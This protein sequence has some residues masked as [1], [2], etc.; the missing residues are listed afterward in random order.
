M[1][2][3]PL[4]I[5]DLAA[6]LRTLIAQVPPGKATTCGG[7]AEALGNGVA[8]RWIGHFLLHH[9][10]GAACFCHRV[11]RAGGRL[12]PYI[13]GGPAEKRRRL[14]AEGVAAGDEAVDLDRCGFDRFVSDRPLERLRRLQE[15]TAAEV[16]LR[17]PE[18]MP[19]LV[20][21][22]DVSY[23]PADEG[24]AA[25]ALIEVATG[26]LIWSAKVR[27]AIRF[28]YITSYL[29]FREL[30]ILLELLGEVRRGRPPG[31]RPLG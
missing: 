2:P 17:A 7:L 20:G 9:E 30:P 26:R 13:G 4:E 8:A 19:P 3:F 28:P 18:T 31:A 24:V 22:L 15:A 1:P 14:E 23:P 25:Y 6:A 11:V 29:T 5:P 27:R 12:G 21:G 16:V 10:H